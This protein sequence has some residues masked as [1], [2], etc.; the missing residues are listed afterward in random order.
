MPETAA[1]QVT[2]DAG[3]A[4]AKVKADADAAAATAAAKATTDAATAAAAAAGKTPAG[5]TPESGAAKPP[6]KY[7]LTIPK[8]ATTFVDA[9]DLDEVAAIAKENAWTNEEAQAYIDL[10][11]EAIG[12][13][14]AG[15]RT[16]TEADPDYGGQKLEASQQLV[17]RV[18]DRVR[19][20]GH[21][22]LEAFRRVLVKTGIGNHIEMF[23]FLAD[24]GKLM[25][26]DQP[27][28]PSGGT[29]E[30]KRSPEDVLYD[31][32]KTA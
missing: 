10:Q 21:P 20:A 27:P 30:V 11:S 18:I 25:R 31:K 1:G 12:K 28:S 9:K 15:F 14:L 8:G 26:E 32:G 29:R 5:V 2:P 19:P 4:A 24:I 17:N 23:A 22:R 3:A 16:E 6:D 13:K 7:A